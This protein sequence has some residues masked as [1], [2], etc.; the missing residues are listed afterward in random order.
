VHGVGAGGVGRDQRVP[1]FVIRDAPAL[2]VVERA[3]APLRSRHDLVDRLLEVVEDPELVGQLDAA[4]I[5]YEG[6]Q[7][8]A[9]MQ[10][11]LVWGLPL[12]L[13]LLFWVFLSRRVSRAG[14]SMLRIGQSRA[15]LRRTSCPVVGRP[16]GRTPGLEGN[17]RAL[18]L[19]WS[20]CCRMH[21]WAGRY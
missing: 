14:E 3:A 17:G 11:L 15:R 19:R 2:G 16:G 21:D 12:G 10:L 6:V 9:L 20:R 1:D 13:L 5:D 8:S 7:P 4:H 18:G